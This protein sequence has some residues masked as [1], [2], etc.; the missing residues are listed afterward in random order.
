LDFPGAVGANVHLSWLDPNK[1]RQMTV[2]GSKKMVVYDDTSPD[3]KIRLYDK[4]VTTRGDWAKLGAYERFSEFQLMLR[5][6]DVLIPKLDFA[7]PLRAECQ[8]F[9][10]CIRSGETPLSDGRSGLQVVQML[11][12]TDRALASSGA[13]AVGIE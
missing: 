5:A 10:D 9:V 7:E 11:M 6:G 2:V 12:A 4:G 3:E 1:V 13:Q 8:H